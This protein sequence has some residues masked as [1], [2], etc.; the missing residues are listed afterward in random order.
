MGTGTSIG[1]SDPAEYAKQAADAG[2]RIK[3]MLA[4]LLNGLEPLAGTWK[5]QGGTSFLSTKAQVETAT[6]K[7]YY[8]LTSLGED[9]AQAGV[10]YNQADEQGSQAI[11]KSEAEFSQ[12][13]NI[14]S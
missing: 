8:A 13:G 11:Q 9:M 1:H 5:G 7:L 12:L 6:N 14:P 4:A 2:E 10:Q 3:N